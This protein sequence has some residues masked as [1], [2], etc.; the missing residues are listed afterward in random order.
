MNLEDINTIAVIG[1]GDMGHGIAEIASLAGYHV[2]L[3]DIKEEF[4]DKA[5]N[6]IKKSME[7]LANK[8]K[9]T[10]ENKDDALNKLS[11]SLDL[12]TAIKDAQLIIEAVPE[13]MT[14]KKEIFQEIDKHSPKDAII[15]SNTSNMSI[16]E[17]ARATQRPD[18]VI[19]LHF[20]NPVI[21]MKLV[22]VIKGE[23]T[24]DET[25]EVMVQFGKKIKKVPVKVLKDSP[26]FIVNRVTAPVSILLGKILENKIEEPAKFDVAL[27]E[28]GVAMGPFELA[29]F[30]GLDIMLHSLEY[31]KKTLGPD[32]EP[33]NWLREKIEKNEL[34][35][36]TGKGIYDWSRGR[37]DFTGVTPSDKIELEDMIAIQVNEATKLLEE[38]VA[39]KSRVIDKAIKNGSGNPF[40]VFG[41]AKGFGYENMARRCEKLAKLHDVETFLPTKMLKGNKIK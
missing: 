13:I 16:T 32:Y 30:V 28:K 38:G 5:I 1:S 40:G 14:L 22:E 11:T 21:I 37:P 29:D 10:Q 35:K 23:A 2:I 33:P 12:K 3:N 6:S 39:E 36:K 19:G 41:L 18:K 15:A 8:G 4:L 24:S 7:K 25:L 9:I 31:F 34:G 17:L 26:G 27:K 20:F